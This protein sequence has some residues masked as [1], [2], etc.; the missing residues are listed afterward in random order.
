M[1]YMHISHVMDLLIRGCFDMNV[2]AH[3][4]FNLPDM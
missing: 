4:V 3:F 2:Q 1:Q